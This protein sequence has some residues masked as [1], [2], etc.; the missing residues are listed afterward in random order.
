MS[1]IHVDTGTPDH[2]DGGGGGSGDGVVT[3]GNRTNQNRPHNPYIAARLQRSSSG[4]GGGDGS[5]SSSIIGRDKL[6][7]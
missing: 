2:R 1:N 4:S 7:A 3:G 6:I 5:G